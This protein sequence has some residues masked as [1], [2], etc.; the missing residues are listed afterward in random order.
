MTTAGA[1]SRHR[2]AADPEAAFRTRAERDHKALTRLAAVLREPTTWRR[3]APGLAEIERLAHKLAGAGG[4]FGFAALSDEAARLERLLE[5]WR[6]RPP[7]E[8]SRR[9]VAAFAQRLDAVLGGLAQ[10]GE[11][12]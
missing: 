11:R 5:R 2:L 9:R 12:R 3:A 7:K 1:F 10:V 4:V 8:I 6:L